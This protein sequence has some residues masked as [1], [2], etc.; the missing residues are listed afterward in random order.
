MRQFIEKC[1]ASVSERLS[2]RELLMDPF[3]QSDLDNVSIGP[4]RSDVK[5]AG[6]ILTMHLLRD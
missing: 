6:K 2:A 3:L 1:I 4:S 5:C